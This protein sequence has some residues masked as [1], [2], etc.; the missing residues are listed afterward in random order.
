MLI[1]KQ[2]SVP[3]AFAVFNPKATKI[4]ESRLG[5]SWRNLPMVAVLSAPTAATSGR[6]VA[7]TG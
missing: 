6:L 1:L 5:E 3:L 4:Q 7:T 2:R